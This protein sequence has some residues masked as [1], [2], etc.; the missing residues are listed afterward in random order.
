MYHL[1]WGIWE[2]NRTAIVAHWNSWR[3]EGLLSDENEKPTTSPSELLHLNNS[4]SM[5]ESKAQALLHIL[6]TINH[7]AR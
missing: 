6:L 1:A 3:K 2:D 4:M 5:L 7:E